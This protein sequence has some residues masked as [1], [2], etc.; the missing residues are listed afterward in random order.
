MAFAVVA[1]MIRTTK[2]RAVLSWGGGDYD[3]APWKADDLLVA[4]VHVGITNGL[5]CVRT[6]THHRHDRQHLFTIKQERLGLNIGQNRTGRVML[7]SHA[8]TI[9][10][11]NLR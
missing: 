9:V 2:V 8:V 5:D 3:L 11:S 4:K 1:R 7:E 6:A 10:Y